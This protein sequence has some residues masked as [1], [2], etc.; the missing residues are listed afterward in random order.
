M[1]D[2]PDDFSPPPPT[3]E[4][5]AARM[6][7]TR[8]L[9][10]FFAGAAVAGVVVQAIKVFGWGLRD[11][12]V[13]PMTAYL[14]GLLFWLI[15]D[16]LA[17]AILWFGIGGRAKR[18]TIELRPIGVA[19]GVGAVFPV[20]LGAAQLVQE[21]APQVTQSGNLDQHGAMRPLPLIVF[22]LYPLLASVLTTRRLDRDRRPP[23]G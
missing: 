13:A 18:Y 3:A 2:R 10:G 11:Q 23:A 19:F 15:V 5:A 17:L 12:R 16:V 14:F 6:H 21:M 22:F 8:T 7:P 20:L 9:V 1:T 4:A